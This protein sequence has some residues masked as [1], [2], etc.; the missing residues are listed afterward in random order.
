MMFAKTGALTLI[1]AAIAVPTVATDQTPRSEAVSALKHAKVHTWRDLYRRN[2]VE[3]LD[4]FLSDDFVI[5]G[6]NGSVQTKSAILEDMVANPW[7][8]PEDFLYTVTGIL[9]PTPDSAIVYGNGD[10]TRQ[11]PDGETCSHNYT[12]S[13]GF[14]LENGTWRPVSSHVSDAS[15]D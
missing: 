4:A 2:D 6:A 13:N 1:L 3:G 15:C 14:R 7:S 8:M 10:S 5:I 9:F 11:R 12:S